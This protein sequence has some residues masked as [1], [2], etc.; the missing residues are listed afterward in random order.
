MNENKT[1]KAL[2]WVV[3]QIPDFKPKTNA[4]K[5]IL[6]VKLYCDAGVKEIKR[7]EAENAELKKRLENA[8]ELH[9]IFNKDIIAILYDEHK[10]PNLLKAKV[11]GVGIDTYILLDGKIDILLDILCENGDSHFLSGRQYKKEWFLIDDRA[12]AEARLAEL[13]G[14]R[15]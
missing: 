14:G 6:T 11:V 7:L 1:A 3:N 8:V 2:Q 13:R 4:E 10:N 15:E 9:D 12:A 5:F